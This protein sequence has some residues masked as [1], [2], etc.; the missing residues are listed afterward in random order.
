MV[1][2]WLTPKPHDD[3][4]SVDLVRIAAALVLLTHPAHALLHPEDARALAGGLQ[5]DGVPWTLG[6]AWAGLLLQLVCSL[7]LL[8][9][10]LVVPAAM[11]SIAVVAGGAALLYAPR[12]YVVGGGAEDGHPGV[13]FN[14]LLL[15]CLSG[16][17]WTYW[18]RRVA[19][20]DPARTGFEFIRI[21]SA[22]ALLAHGYGPFL[23]WDVAGMHAWGEAMSHDG[24]PMGVALVWS[25]K[26][27][28][29][30]CALLR[31]SRRLMVPACFGHLSYL[32]PALW[33]EHHLS[34]WF[35]VGPGENGMEYVVMLV[36]CAVACIL[37]YWPQRGRQVDQA[38][39]PAT[40]QHA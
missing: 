4:R 9:P 40:L 22:L 31:L 36:V 11:G 38:Q 39:P 2:D 5:T 12:W 25:I 8:V 37:A 26:A 10:R 1:S 17:V 28:E 35:V 32:V 23:R 34:T 20:A 27:L 21:Y 24:W 6:L 30:S 7:A 16:V 13:E 15:A 19:G 3:R 14:M 29:L 18:P 33:I